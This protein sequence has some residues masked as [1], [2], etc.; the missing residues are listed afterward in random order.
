MLVYQDT[1]LPDSDTEVIKRMFVYSDARLLDS[2]S[3]EMT[4]TLNSR[5]L[6][7]LPLSFLT[8]SQS[9]LFYWVI[10]VQQS[11]T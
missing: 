6:V 7:I 8:R 5:M 4:Q 3:E 11:R 10:I 1:R 2:A 9:A